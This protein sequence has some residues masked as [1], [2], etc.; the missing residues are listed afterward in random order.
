ML[1]RNLVYTA[2]T[3]AERVAVLVGEPSALA[4]ALRRRDARRRHTRLAELVSRFPSGVPRP[5]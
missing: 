1:T 3:R 4:L 5:M 2:V